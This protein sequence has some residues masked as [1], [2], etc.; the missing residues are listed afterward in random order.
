MPTYPIPSGFS[1]TVTTSTGSGSFS[2]SG[3]TQNTFW[4]PSRQLARDVMVFARDQFGRPIQQ[5]PGSTATPTSPYLTQG[6]AQLGGLAQQG[7]PITGSAEQLGAST[8]R[9]DYL[10][11]QSNPWLERTF[12]AG[13]RGVTNEYQNAVLP[14]LET[15]FARGGVGNSSY[16]AALGRSQDALGTS[17]A[18]LAT[19]VYGGA[20]ESE[21][22]RQTQALAMAPMLQ[23]LK[24]ADVDQM[25][26]AGGI[27]QAEGQRLLDAD[28]QK[29]R[30]QQMEPWQRAGLAAG[31]YGQSPVVS[32]STFQ[33]SG[34]QSQDGKQVTVAP[35][36]PPA[37]QPSAMSYF[38]G[39]LSSFL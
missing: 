35:E 5:Y 31:L 23:Q 19:Q 26:R 8:L 16:N 27:Q 15:R 39:L 21:R 22:G 34:T 17:L 2:Q 12:Q 32:G 14:G 7:S 1:P 10:N 24:Y 25:L 36:A 30:F 37:Q 20:Y 28:V 4:R 9:G 33:Q 6:A 29:W 18:D 13:A 38:M 11:P 3:S